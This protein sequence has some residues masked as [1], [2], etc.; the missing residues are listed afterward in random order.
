MDLVCFIDNISLC[1]PQTPRRARWAALVVWPPV[2]GALERFQ[3]TCLQQHEIWTTSA[4]CTPCAIVRNS[5][6]SRTLPSQC[7]LQF[8]R[9]E[10]R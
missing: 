5:D 9:K 6:N 8:F 1:P 3:L 4:V 2:V 7:L 10:L